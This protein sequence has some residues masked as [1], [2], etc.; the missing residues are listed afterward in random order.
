[1]NASDAREYFRQ[2]FGG[3]PDIIGSA[4]GRVNIIGEHTDYNGGQVLPIAID[5]RTFVAIRARPDAALSRIVSQGESTAAEF[6]VRR[7][8]ASG[9][10]WDYMTGVCAAMES[11]GA[12]LP[13][14]EA[15]VQSDVPMGSGLSSS[16]ALEVAT[17]V[18]LAQ[19]VSQA[20]DMRKLAM[21]SW[22]VETQFVGVASGVMDQFA[23][24]LCLEGHALHLWCD[25]LE[26]EQ[27][28]MPDAVLIFD[29]ASPRELRASEF[30]QRRAEC[31]EALA[32]LR[33]SR[34]SLLHLA[35]ASLEEVQLADLNPRIRKRAV[36]VVEENARVEKLV[37]QL[38]QTR[39][40]AGDLLYQSHESLR[41]NY[42]CS[43]PELDWFVD[44]VRGKPGVTGA[45]LT[46]AGWG[47]CAI[48]V[49]DLD[50][51]SA[52]AKDL[53]ARYET[54]FGRKPGT[55]LTR[56]GSGARIED[57]ASR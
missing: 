15:I 20:P 22:Q 56:A 37:I 51:L 24:A 1:M 2:V 32:V 12:R 26:T 49:G 9:G 47:G 39:T 38:M 5:R 55:W 42:E 16:A 50:G 41:D 28:I 19:I 21:L 6:D 8:A 14:F 46:G 4:P 52:A 11:A 43:T 10:W 7:F 35:A 23:S 3:Y 29:T 45:R 54:R 36:H 13:Q 53:S 17:A 57:L 18:S 40:V 33:R 25:T 48:A 44:S 30:N 34:P 27:V 31:E